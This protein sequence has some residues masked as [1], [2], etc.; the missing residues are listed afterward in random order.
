MI[1]TFVFLNSPIVARLSGLLYNSLTYPS[2]PRRYKRV[3]RCGTGFF[4]SDSHV[5]PLSVFHPC[6]M[7]GGVVGRAVMLVARGWQERIPPDRRGGGRAGGGCGAHRPPARG[8]RC[9]R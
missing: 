9:P 8:T 5:F 3:S 4:A 2:N 7:Q 6:A 1:R